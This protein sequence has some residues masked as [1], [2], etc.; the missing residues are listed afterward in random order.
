MLN[1]P[2]K[3]PETNKSNKN[4]KNKNSSDI[5]DSENV[6]EEQLIDTYY[7]A[8]QVKNKGSKVQMN[9]ENSEDFA[10][11]AANV[12]STGQQKWKN[13]TQSTKSSKYKYLHKSISLIILDNHF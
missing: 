6:S 8:L 7:E 10:K 3:A 1:E 9:N 4:K 11:I 13:S 2:V 5:A 12:K